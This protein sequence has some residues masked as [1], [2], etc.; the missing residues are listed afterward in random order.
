MKNH[1]SNMGIKNSV[2]A[3]LHRVALIAM[4]HSSFVAPSQN[5][6]EGYLNLIP[7]REYKGSS[8]KDSPL[9]SN[10][11]E[12]ESVLKIKTGATVPTN[13]GIV[14]IYRDKKIL[15]HFEIKTDI[16]SGIIGSTKENP[17][18]DPNDNLFKFFINQELP[19][20]TNAYLTYELN[21]V[22]DINAVSR[23]INDRWAT[24][25]YLIK[26]QN[27]WTSQKEEIDIQWLHKGAN[28]I[29]FTIP[30][31]AN[32]Q[33]Q[34]KNLKIVFENKKNS[35][36]S[37]L[38]HVEN[39][40]VHFIKDNKMYIKGFVKNANFNHIKVYAENQLLTIK[41]G[42][43]EG[44]VELSELIKN[45][46]FI[47][48]KVMDGDI[49]LG[50]EIISIDNLVEADKI[51]P[52]EIASNSSTL[53]CKA[54]R[55]ENLQIDGASIKI[56]QN[57]LKNDKQITITKLRNVDIAPMSSGMIN[58]TKGGVGYR[59]LPDGTNFKKEVSI[60]IEYDEKLIPEGYTAQDISSFYFDTNLKNWVAVKKD[61]L[62]E[63]DKIVKSLTNHFT[64]YINGIIQTPE[65][66]ETTGF[67]STMMNDIK[68]ADPSSEMT[69]ISPPE[70][71]QKGDANV[72]Y[73]I[74][75]PAGR[76]GMQP[77]L[78]IQYSNEGGNGWLGQGWGIN[79]PSI[80]IDSRWGVPLFDAV[81]ES[82]MYTM[83]GEQLMYPKIG[84][85]DWM[86]NRHYDVDGATNVYNTAPRPRITSAIFTPRKQGGFA[87]IERLGN[88]SSDY[89]WK[90]TATDGGI[91]WYGGK[92]GVVD[93]AV[94]KND[95]G[96]IV[97]W[98]LFMSEDVFG[99]NIKYYYS[100]IILLNQVGDNSN[101]NNGRVFNI[102]KITYTG[103]NDQDGNYSV[104]FNTQNTIRNDV[105]FNGRMGI[106]QVEPY[107][108]S[109]IIVKKANTNETIRKYTF[110]IG[111]GKFQKGQL[112]S[113]SELDKDN[114][115]FYTH[116]FDYY[117]DI[118][119]NGTDIYYNTDT[120]E[121]I[122]ND[123]IPSNCDSMAD[124]DGD[125]V[126]GSCDL[127]PNESGPASNHGCPIGRGF[128][129]S[130]KKYTQFFQNLSHN[131]SF[132]P[133]FSD[134][135][136]G[137]KPCYLYNDDFLISSYMTSFNSTGSLLGS[138]KSKS[139]S[140]GFYIGLGIGSNRFTKMTTFGIQFNWANDKSEGL[141]SLIDINGDGLEDIVTK[142]SS[143]G[144]FYKKHKKTVTYGI[145]NEPIVTH[146]FEP[147]APIIGI[148]NFYHS[149]GRSR[150]TNFQVTFGLKKIGGFVGWDKSK[151]NSETDM[152]FTDGNGDG[153]M[154]IVKNGIVFFN[155][156]D[157]NGNPTFIPDSKNTENL[158]I[159]ARPKEI[160]TPDE[161]NQ[162]NIT[163]PAFDVVKVWEAPA[164]GA[165]QIDNAIEL[166][167]TSK[168]AIVTIEKNKSNNRIY[169]GQFV[170]WSYPMS[171]I[172]YEYNVLSTGSKLD[173]S[174][175]FYPARIKSLNINGVVSNP[176][177]DYYFTH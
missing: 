68:A 60:A 133:N 37:S 119:V 91:S 76:K 166:T 149:Y 11:T 124:I 130:G 9:V 71:S 160:D 138:S 53:L 175:G 84:E 93:N 135:N 152:Y 173:S 62:I 121:T 64:D 158:V 154:D 42:E 14:K 65:S 129:N 162:E 168:E 27:G 33:Y 116:T 134:T 81:N 52:L 107:F 147:N 110:D 132:S 144:L 170:E 99:N 79:T 48:L 120:T 164:D 108:L 103:F 16:V 105:S 163:L 167:D 83:A 13:N 122:C 141:T 12:S 142:T 2:N 35:S 72:S 94:I 92:N 171:N 20:N 18:D 153:L 31:G 21:G 38:L 40:N 82:E 136:K 66:P 41:Q 6:I 169:C 127:C 74:K 5:I 88:N 50:Q 30:K 172:M 140:V 126:R 8:L 49:F 47:V 143:N 45:K 19:A 23:S 139:K 51:F 123:N 32:Y 125:G 165:I 146:S 157:T 10:T 174:C 95:Q 3:V 73:P 106:K 28:K 69:L 150:S 137:D 115:I 177:T 176:T 98:G 97:N 25:G 131:F 87:K 114:T 161:Y 56:N 44:F 39:Q 22:Q 1:N 43:F 112:K 145:N 57:S 46:N 148:D 58:V 75:I 102:Q 70:V 100:N 29:L 111:Y 80:T 63:H 59:F 4:L 128:A 55:N 17:L 77:Q 7:S 15:N 101:L 26:K 67:T 96:K 155:R 104:E 113:V 109:D 159:T 85:S 90:V 78:A 36:I 54:D 156:L 89:Y 117:N 34:I 118:T 24:G 151:N 61:T 86:P